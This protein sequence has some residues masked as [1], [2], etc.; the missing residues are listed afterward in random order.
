MGRSKDTSR[1]TSCAPINI[2]VDIEA[3][4][5][6]IGNQF[7]LD[8]KVAHEARMSP[9]HHLEIHPTKAGLFQ[10]WADPPPPDIFLG[11]WRHSFRRENPS[12]G[13]RRRRLFPPFFDLAREPVGKRC[14]AV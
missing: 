4:A 1:L 9:A 10:L 11:H 2:L 5:E 8:A 12:A 7:P 6:L 14:P 13:D 3:V